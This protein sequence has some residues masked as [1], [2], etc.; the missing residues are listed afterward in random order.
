[1]TL[2][3]RIPMS[4]LDFGL[5]AGVDRRSVWPPAGEAGYGENDAIWLYDE[6]QRVGVHA[7]LG[8]SGA[9]YPESF[10]RMTV[11]LPD[12]NVLVKA[13]HGPQHTEETPSGA[14]MRVRCDAP[15]ERWF[16]SYDGPTI[17]CT[18]DELR[19]GP[20]PSDR[21][22]TH[23]VFEAHARMVAPAFPQGAFFRDRADYAK[24]TASHFFGGFRC[25][26]ALV[27]DATL[28]IGDQWRRI[29]GPGLRTHR[30]GTRTMQGSA[31]VPVAKYTG[32]RWVHAVFPSGREIYHSWF[33]GADGVA[34]DGEAFVRDDGVFY[35]AE[36][37]GPAPMSLDGA[38]ARGRFSF[39]SELGE[40]VIDWEVVAD[41]FQSLMGEEFF[42]VQ[43]DSPN[44][45]CLAMSQAFVRYRWGDEVTINMMERSVGTK[46]L[47]RPV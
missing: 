12:G 23:L 7:W 27:A 38:G 15:F 35:R 13:T 26:Q 46:T 31:A 45:D 36:V 37:H 28:K 10:E 19:R 40:T 6:G 43:W 25:E 29:S 33:G 21:A 4:R 1:M 41:S 17:L 30:K 3:D 5:D 22:P 42:G 2:Y 24:T 47:Q 20:V 11:F 18:V 8:H 32:H 16:F 14:H 39:T 34:I 9:Q 44:P